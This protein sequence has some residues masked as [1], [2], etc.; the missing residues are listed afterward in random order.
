MDLFFLM[1]AEQFLVYSSLKFPFI[2]IC[3]PQFVWFCWNVI[4]SV[5]FVWFSSLLVVGAG[6][7]RT[8]ISV[9]FLFPQGVYKLLQM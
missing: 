4:F 8:E 5:C 7:I 1:T 3:Y 9:S 6:T 2:I